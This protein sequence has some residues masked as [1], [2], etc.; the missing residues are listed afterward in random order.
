[1]RDNRLWFL[2]GQHRELVE[3]AEE[4][5]SEE[6][7]HGVT[8]HILSST[9]TRWK[10]SVLWESHVSSKTWMS[11]YVFPYR[12]L[13]DSSNATGLQRKIALNH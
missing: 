9:C 6:G 7:S 11:E 10:R 3:H 13:F 2:E 8:T 1:M 5:K 4:D 12:T